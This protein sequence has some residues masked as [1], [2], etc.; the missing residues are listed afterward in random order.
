MF[1]QKLFFLF[2]LFSV[3][4]T[5]LIAQKINGI[6]I[7]GPSEP[8]LTLDMYNELKMVNA[9]W[10]GIVPEKLIYR[11]NLELREDADNYFWA[12]TIDGTIQSIELA[13]KADLKVFLKPHLILQKE[14][15][16]VDKTTGADWRG[17]IALASENDWLLFEQNYKEYI[18]TLVQIAE[19]YEV[20]LFGIGTELASFI[21]QR[22]Q[23][24]FNL[25]KE[26]R[27]IYSG[28][29]IYCA[30][31]DEYEMVPFWNELDYIGVDS[32]FPISKKKSPSVKRTLKKWFPISI[33]L[34]SLSN[35][36]NKKIIFTEFGYR[37]IP[38]AGREPW[39]HD[40]GA[41]KE[42]DYRAQTHLYEAFFQS[43]WNEPWVAGGFS[44]RWYMHE[45]PDHN[46]TFSVQNKPALVVLQTWYEMSNTANISAAIDTND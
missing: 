9:N 45:L 19:L 34:K 12:Q 11:H 5:I 22:P 25:I 13:K 27:N 24:W 37:N 14:I 10:A 21:E 42:F 4:N 6:S 1:L 15:G 33:K 18:L 36:Y 23:F 26:I 3:F 40:K 2:F 31:W 30:N 32:Y 41:S 17:T 29:L 35:Y 20:E 44:W 28:D 16:L 7:G 43:F 8:H 39:T 38:Y 46:T